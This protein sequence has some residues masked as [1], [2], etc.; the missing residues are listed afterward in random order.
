[1]DYS[2]KSKMGFLFGLTMLLTMEAM[3]GHD[4]HKSGGN[5]DEEFANLMLD[6][7][8]KNRDRA[9]EIVQDI[10]D[11]VNDFELFGNL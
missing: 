8:G 3:E 1:V 2:V 4:P 6:W 5:I 9:G 11:K 10:K 7:I